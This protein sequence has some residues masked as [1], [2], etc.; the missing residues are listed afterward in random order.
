MLQ[1]SLFGNDHIRSDGGTHHLSKTITSVAAISH[2]L[3]SH[4]EILS[5]KGKE[6]NTTITF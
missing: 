6:R 4:I 5:I 1:I 3:P 2:D